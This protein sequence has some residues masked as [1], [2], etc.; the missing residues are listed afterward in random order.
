M[1]TLLCNGTVVTPDK[2]IDNGGVLFEDGKIVDVGNTDKVR[3]KVF[4][5]SK[6]KIHL[7]IIDAKKRIIMPGFINTHH[8]LYSTFS[9][10]MYIP[11]T[12]A[13][14]FVEILE[15][16][17]WKL[18]RVL[19]AEDIY[20][21]SLIPLIECVKNGVT[22]IIDHHES[23]TFQIGSL[24]EI[25]KAVEKIGIRA[26]LCMGVSDRYRKGQE[27]LDECDRFLKSLADC[28]SDLVSSMVGLHA[29]FTVNNDI[30]AKSVAIAKKYGVGMHIH[31][32]ED[33]SDQ[34][35]S[36]K[37]YKMRVVERL[38]KYGALGTKTALIH[39]IHIDEKEK[40]IIKDTC[41]NV[42]HNPESNMNNAVGCADALGM[43]SK[44]ITVGL[45]TDG[46]SSDMLYHMRCAY[47][48]HRHN[49][50]DPRV[51]FVEAPTMLLKNNPKII[52]NITGKKLGRIEKGLP[53]D[54]I[55]MDYVPPTPL[56]SNNILGHLIFGMVDTTVDTVICNGKTLM[57]DKKLEGISEDAICAKSREL[58]AK[59]WK[60][61]VKLA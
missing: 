9:R 34:K 3:A 47:V 5:S 53:A 23:Q 61:I 20:Y 46:M 54:L 26:N 16:L 44:G 21:S 58:S 43:L 17:W 35:D 1:L 49:K 42:V 13:K 28:P 36:V 45:G 50:K 18:D 27:G 57:K 38:K 24:D 4:K 39:C 56:T 55:V 8:H 29:A 7:K 25:R 2:V 22:S 30:L 11:G 14:N 31:C 33:I 19:T 60:R 52:E 48:L 12:P 15:K 40:K 6:Q 59:V 37:K 32:A 41:T 51:A 10:G